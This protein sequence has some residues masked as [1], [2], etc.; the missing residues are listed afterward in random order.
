MSDGATI[1]VLAC[2][3]VIV[4]LKLVLYYIDKK[5][6]PVGAEITSIIDSLSNLHEKVNQIVPPPVPKVSS[7]IPIVVEKI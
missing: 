4:L 2:S 1:S 7:P 3:A 5:Y 6:P